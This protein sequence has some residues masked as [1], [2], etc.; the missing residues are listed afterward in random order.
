MINIYK[1]IYYFLYLNLIQWSF[2]NLSIDEV[3]DVYLYTFIYIGIYT[4]TNL[5]VS[6]AFGV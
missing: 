4:V 2:E 5:I 3:Y 1:G 6:F